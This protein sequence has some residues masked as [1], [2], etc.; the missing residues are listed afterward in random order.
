M[1]RP[2]VEGVY[3]RPESRYW[4]ISFTHPKTGEQVR[5][6]SKTTIK[7]Q[8]QQLYAQMYKEAFERSH[9]NAPVKLSVSDLIAWYKKNF[10]STRGTEADHGRFDSTVKRPLEFFKGIVACE[11]TVQKIH[12][13]IAVRMTDGLARSSINRELVPF[14]AAY[15]AAMKTDGMLDKNPFN[16]IK[17]YDVED[18]RR[19]RALSDKEQALL[20]KHSRGALHDIIYFAL[21]TGL[22]V[23]NI[24]ALKW[25]EIDMAHG[26]FSFLVRKGSKIKT[27]HHS[28]YPELKEWLSKRPSI[29]THVFSKANGMPYTPPGPTHSPYV[30]L[31]EKLAKLYNMPHCTFHDLRHTHITDYLN[32]GGDIYR[33]SKNVG[34][35][36]TS[37][38]DRYGH[39]SNEARAQDMNRINKRFYHSNEIENAEFASNVSK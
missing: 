16:S 1:A 18:L 29:G 8:A 14:R 37:M 2:K 28:M 17:P 19:D 38:T 11:L 7:Q 10:V 13:Y 9:F 4:W 15:N 20:L 32:A 23:G 5:V 30:R 21:M 12:D 3:P 25:S 36:A 33:L 39:L 31:I 27:Y 6:S 22:R 35:A 34:H 26:R 24:L